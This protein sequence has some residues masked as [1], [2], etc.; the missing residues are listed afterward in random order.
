MG[1]LGRLEGLSVEVVHSHPQVLL[2][3]VLG[4]SLC[5]PILIVFVYGSLDRKKREIALGRVKCYYA[6]KG[7]HWLAIGDFNAIMF[8]SEKRGGRVRGKSCSLFGSFKDSTTLHDLGFKG[9][10][11]TW[12]RGGTFERLDRTI[13]NDAWLNIFPNSLV[14]HLS[15]LK[16]D[17]RPLFLSL[18][19]DL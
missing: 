2:V 14:T 8:G 4:Q 13:R 18:R 5:Q 1:N 11:F 17:H 7:A 16:F 3:R 10:S 9:M 19:S 15:R 12:C 6:S